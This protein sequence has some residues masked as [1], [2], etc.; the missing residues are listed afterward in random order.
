MLNEKTI[1]NLEN[2]GGNRW[3]KGNYDRIYFSPESLGLKIERYNTGN[4]FHAEYN[5]E[6]ISNSRASEIIN[7]KIYVNVND[8][9][10][11]TNNDSSIVASMIETIKNTIDNSK[12]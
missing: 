1:E 2:I 11:H 5:G 9:K 7:A 12:N 6:K 8:G 3:T 10:I 4:I